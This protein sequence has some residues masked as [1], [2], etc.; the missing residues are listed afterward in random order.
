LSRAFTV[1]PD[2]LRI[3]V[4]LTPK[5]GRDALDG[6]TA[7]SDG[8][9]VVKARV[10]AV[11]ED[12]AANAALLALLA[13]TLG[14][15]KSDAVLRQVGSTRLDHSNTELGNTRV[16]VGHTARLKIVDIR[17]NGA[18]LAARMTAAVKEDSA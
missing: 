2:G 12:G 6:V 3:S 15:A 8:R 7:L 4:R 16:Q 1:T 9:E 14:V 5:G 11:P 17:G 10:R 18:A 13:K